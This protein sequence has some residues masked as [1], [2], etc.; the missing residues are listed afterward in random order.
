MS[1]RKNNLLQ[2]HTIIDGDMSLSSLTS[3]VTNIQFL[4]NLAIQL[5][6]SGSPVGTFEVQ[7]SID[8]AQD[9]NGNVTNSGNWV[10]VT[11]NPSPDTSQGSPIFI[12]MQQLAAPWI[13]VVYTKTSGSGT[14][15]AY[16]SGKM[17]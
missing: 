3:S 7:V 9:N 15:N 6:F 17:I 1:G 4:D 8:Y 13:R 14:L 2:F 10:P 5:N 16:I 12:N 11:L